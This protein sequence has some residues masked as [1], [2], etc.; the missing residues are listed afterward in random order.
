VGAAPGAVRVELLA[1]HAPIRQVFPR[2]ESA[3][4]LTRPGGD[5]SSW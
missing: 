3:L 4:D 1:V 2:R 5:V